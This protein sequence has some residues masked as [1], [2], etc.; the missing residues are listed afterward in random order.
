MIADLR[1][2]QLID[3]SKIGVGTD[4]Q[5]ERVASL[6]NPLRE[7]VAWAYMRSSARPGLPDRDFD[8]WVDEIVTL[9]DQA[10]NER[11]G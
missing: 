3:L 8:S 5:Y 7:L 4:T 1:D 10:Q 11:P 2:L 6:D 9:L